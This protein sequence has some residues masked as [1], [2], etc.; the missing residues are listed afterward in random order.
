MS[1]LKLSSAEIRQA[2]LDFYSQ[3]GHQPLPSGSLVPEDLSF[4]LFKLMLS[5]E[6]A[7]DIAIDNMDSHESTKL[8]I[9]LL[10]WNISQ[11]NRKQLLLLSRY[12]ES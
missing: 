12:L 2:F 5:K 7:I 9:E 10:D 6:I 11:F 8:I 4:D 1:A 3:W